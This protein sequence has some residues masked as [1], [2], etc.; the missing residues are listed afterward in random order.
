[1][2][3]CFFFFSLSL[4]E[5]ATLTPIGNSSVGELIPIVG[6]EDAASGNQ[7][8][9]FF[10]SLVCILIHI[11]NAKNLYRIVLTLEQ[12]ICQAVI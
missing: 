9:I 10:L 12:K 1:M 3:L 6:N 4:S 2:N 11:S 7:Y 5:H 8:S